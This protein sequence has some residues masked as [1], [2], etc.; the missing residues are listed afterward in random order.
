MRVTR[1]RKSGAKE[2]GR[3][4]A[5]YVP[6]AVRRSTETCALLYD[7]GSCDP[8]SAGDLLASANLSDQAERRQTLERILAAVA[9][10]GRTW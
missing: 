5:A 10:V 1:L 9:N 7:G 8:V 2:P 4:K 6:V 3:C